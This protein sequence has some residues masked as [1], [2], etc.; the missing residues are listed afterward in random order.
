ME[1][2]KGGRNFAALPQRQNKIHTVFVRFGLILP[3]K[4]LFPKKVINNRHFAVKSF[5]Y[6]LLPLVFPS[7]LQFL[8]KQAFQRIGR[9]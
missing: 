9:S 6:S 2:F 4:T 1:E 5:V 8:Y 7:F 3:L